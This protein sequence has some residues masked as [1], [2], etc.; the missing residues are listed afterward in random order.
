MESYG[1]EIQWGGEVYN[2]LNETKPYMGSGYF[3]PQNPRKTTYARK[4]QVVDKSNTFIEL[5]DVAINT[6]ADNHDCYDVEY[7]GYK[8]EFF[9]YYS[10]FGGPYGLNCKA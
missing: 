7:Y 2:P 3:I 10:M 1:A 5:A 4:L 6:I 8:G 9:R